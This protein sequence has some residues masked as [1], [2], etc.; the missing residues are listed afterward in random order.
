AVVFMV[1]IAM[2]GAS[3]N[4]KQ[5]AVDKSIEA[6]T[7]QGARKLAAANRQPESASMTQRGVAVA[8]GMLESQKGLESA[9]GHR[10]E[11]A[12]LALKPAEWLLLHFGVAVGFGLAGLLLGGGSVLWM[13][14]GLFF[15]LAAPWLYLSFAQGRRLKAFRAQLADTLQLMAG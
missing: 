9:L 8:E 2:G 7:R 11:A 5:D 10:L 4:Q 15:G 14:L 12:G 1:V 6:Y 13:I 3:A